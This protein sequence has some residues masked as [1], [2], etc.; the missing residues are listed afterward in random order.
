MKVHSSSI[1][2]RKA[3]K[4]SMIS[5]KSTPSTAPSQTS[6]AK[7]D[8]GVELLIGVAGW[9]Y[10]DWKGIVYS[11]KESRGGG[12]LHAV[13]KLFDVIEIN[14]SFYR[15]PTE[16]T[17]R[18][19]AGI[20]EEF[21]NFQFTAKLPSALT[22]EEKRSPNEI[23]EICKAFK[24]TFTPLTQTGKLDTTLLQ[25]PPWTEDTEETRDLIKRSVEALQPLEVSVE[26][27]NLSFLKSPTGQ[28]PSFLPFLEQLG[29][30]YVNVDLPPGR[31]SLPPT[32]IN[33][34]RIAYIRL[35]GRNSK[36]WFT[37]SAGR[38]EKYDYH[39]SSAELQDWVRR[40][41]ELSQRVQKVYVITNNHFKGQAPANAIDLLELLNRHPRSPL[42]PTLVARFPRGS[43]QP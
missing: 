39:Y 19:W 10:T 17:T 33:T 9:S 12:A 22:H 7:V 18:K 42:P 3:N 24:S 1:C 20:V 29:A 11:S 5:K 31:S 28:P 16:E 15:L 37:R 35:H 41:E 40:I 38:D 14:S 30:T 23:E 25:F 21:P 26:P 6:T 32:T 27:R 36:A 13:A 34:S 43:S 4:T 2:L 8:N